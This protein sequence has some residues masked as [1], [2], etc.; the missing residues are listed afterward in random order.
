MDRAEILEAF[1]EALNKNAVICA[2]AISSEEYAQF[3]KISTQLARKKLL[4]LYRDGRADRVRVPLNN[5]GGHQYRYILKAQ[6]SNG[7]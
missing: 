5:Q 7:R 1:H 2:E 3:A 4:R 6:D